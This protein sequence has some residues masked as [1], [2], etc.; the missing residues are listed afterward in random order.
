ML[1]LS[2]VPPFWCVGSCSECGQLELPHAD[3]AMWAGGGGPP[4]LMHHAL[5]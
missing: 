3:G 2:G 5:H 4:G 1:D